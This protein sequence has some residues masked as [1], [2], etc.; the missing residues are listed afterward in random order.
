MISDIVDSGLDLARLA[1]SKTSPEPTRHFPRCQ[2]QVISGKLKD[3]QPLR[4][5]G[6]INCRQRQDLLF[7]AKHLLV[8]EC[9]EAQCKDQSSCSRACPRPAA[10]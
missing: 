9:S 1:L 8:I 7:S 3:P 4:R 10:D 5:R 6:C 2:A